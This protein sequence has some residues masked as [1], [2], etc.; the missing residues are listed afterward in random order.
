MSSLVFQ[1]LQEAERLSGSGP[2]H[3][4]CGKVSDINSTAGCLAVRGGGGSAVTA[5]DEKQ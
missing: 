1:L 4:Q 5:E 2:P 3:S